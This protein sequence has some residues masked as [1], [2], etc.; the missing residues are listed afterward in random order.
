MIEQVPIDADSTDT[1]AER[2]ND[3]GIPDTSSG[4]PITRRELLELVV[5]CTVC[6][7]SHFDTDG[8]MHPD[9][10]DR[11][12]FAGWWTPR[13]RPLAEQGYRRQLV[14]RM[15]G[16]APGR[17]EQLEPVW[18]GFDP[19]QVAAAM[20]ESQRINPDHR[21]VFYMGGTDSVD[22][23][24][25]PAGDRAVIYNEARL[26]FRDLEGAEIGTDHSSAP[27]A[28]IDEDMHLRTG[29]RLGWWREAVPREPDLLRGGRFICLERFWL[30]Y[31]FRADA[32]RLAGT[33]MRWDRSAEVEDAVSH[34]ADCHL[35]NH[36]AG[37]VVFLAGSAWVSHETRK[38]GLTADD[39]LGLVVTELE[40]RG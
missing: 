18:S 32:T 23:D 25:V 2:P 29:D 12:W 36:A 20:A 40:H 11:G 30:R 4:A 1:A 13:M 33:V 19:E 22:R 26:P 14:K 5:P 21:V 15:T 24:V 10:I 8:W 34:I 16:R 27:H 7:Q 35:D 28:D 9:I 38:Y 31:P 17:F 37:R 39:L 3:P 6:A